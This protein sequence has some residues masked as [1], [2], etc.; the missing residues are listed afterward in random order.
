MYTH[1]MKTVIRIWGNSLA[2]R[3][4]KTYADDAGFVSGA[5]VQ[6]TPAKDGLRIV[7]SEDAL[8]DLLA[9][10]TPENLHGETSTDTPQGIEQW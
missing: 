8:D 9:R 3:I 1:H 10:I 6:L 5:A 2:I 4:P 7:R